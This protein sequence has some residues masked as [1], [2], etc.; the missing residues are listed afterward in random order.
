MVTLIINTLCVL[1][2][3]V[4]S[5][6]NLKIEKR[7][8]TSLLLYKPLHTCFVS[9]YPDKEFGHYIGYTDEDCRNVVILFGN[10][11]STGQDFMLIVIGKMDQVWMYLQLKINSYLNPFNDKCG[12]SSK[13]TVNSKDKICY[14]Y[15]AYGNKVLVKNNKTRTVSVR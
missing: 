8:I 13:Y 10:C 1:S 11:M 9:P 5:T 2:N 3:P 7:S 15:S 12:K 6:E 4:N 14:Y